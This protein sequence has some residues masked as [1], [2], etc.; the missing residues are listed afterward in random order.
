MKKVGA[1]KVGRYQAD[2][3]E[4]PTMAER[5][6]TPA[7]RMSMKLWV[8]PE[9]PVPVK[10]V[11]KSPNSEITRT[12]KSI[13]LNVPV[14]DNMFQVPKGMKVREM[15]FNRGPGGPRSPQ[16][17]AQAATALANAKQLA[18]GAMMYI[19][20]YDGT[21][22]PMRDAA[23][24]QKA[25]MPYVKNAQLFK[26]PATGQPFR[27]AAGLSGRKL[28]GVKNPAGTVL[29]YSA[30]PEPGGSHIVAY[31]DGH[32]QDV[33]AQRWTIL[34]QEQKLPTR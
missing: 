33:A 11:T 28:K 17:M 19:Q 20:D 21:L 14:A 12:L 13:R 25:L 18:V 4:Q 26:S 7:G 9:V 29:F 34:A 6:G 8:S 10:M 30:V 5:S 22:P 24:L 15:T 16:Q 2:I 32:V 3:Y 23:S 31:V 27:P 1:E